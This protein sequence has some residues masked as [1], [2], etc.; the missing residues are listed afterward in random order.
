MIDTILYF[1]RT[2]TTA[3]RTWAE[4]R[5]VPCWI[6]ELPGGW[7]LLRTAT[8]DGLLAGASTSPETAL[9]DWASLTAEPYSLSDWV[10]RG[11][12]NGEVYELDEDIDPLPWVVQ[13]LRPVRGLIARRG[14][15]TAELPILATTDKQPAKAVLRDGWTL[16]PHEVPFALAMAIESADPSL[17]LQR[18]GDELSLCLVADGD[19]I[20][21]WEWA[22]SGALAATDRL[23][24]GAVG[25]EVRDILYAPRIG[26]EPF[27]AVGLRTDRALIQVLGSQGNS[28]EILP[29]LVHALG[30]P[31]AARAHLAGELDLAESEGGALTAEP[32]E[33]VG[34]AIARWID[35]INRQVAASRSPRRR[36]WGAIG[37][38]VFIP[39]AVLLL[40]LLVRDLIDGHE[41]SWGAWL[42]SVIAVLAVP[43][44][45]AAIRHWWVLRGTG[46]T[47]P[48]TL[49]SE[50]QA[51]QNNTRLG[52]WF[53][54]RGPSTAVCLILVLVCLGGGIYMWTDEA[55]LRQQGVAA[56]ARVVSVEDDAALV[57]FAD[58]QGRSI[59][60]YLDSF[61]TPAVGEAVEVIYDPSDPEHVVLAD[62][63]RSPL[64][65]VL[66]GAS[67]IALLVLAALT[68]TGVIDWQRVSDWLY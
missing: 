49:P 47:D 6:E 16:I 5:G 60:A 8:V 54:R 17:A 40:T 31:D 59:Q 29:K 21:S 39:V 33:H 2:T 11:V 1:V 57:E 61:G 9:L 62:E 19:V 20:A 4:A 41:V 63:F 51:V 55:P 18:V 48:K 15:R 53:N 58:R 42:R 34:G 24:L 36:L 64:G 52:R 25:D 32:S 37:G 27:E 28:A 3:A 67:M 38:A 68:W 65:Y 12:K 14:D 35:G 44:C 45:I 46:Q 13:D 30:L 7:V 50:Y 10:L 26:V 22:V 56:T 66:L 43:V 23:P